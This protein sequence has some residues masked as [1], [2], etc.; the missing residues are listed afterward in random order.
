VIAPTV[1]KSL[2][3]LERLGIVHELTGKQRGRL[4]KHAA[5]E[6]VEPERLYRGD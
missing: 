5:V 3:H 6:L 2:R 4:A 1:A